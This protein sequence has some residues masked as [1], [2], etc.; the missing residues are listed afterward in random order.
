MKNRLQKQI[1]SACCTQRSSFRFTVNKELPQFHKN[2]VSHNGPQQ[3]RLSC[4]ST[5]AVALEK[6]LHTH[7][8]ALTAAVDVGDSLR[9][10]VSARNLA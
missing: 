1:R 6:V 3:G 10:L 2:Q 5:R 4:V 7:S 9:T 8:C